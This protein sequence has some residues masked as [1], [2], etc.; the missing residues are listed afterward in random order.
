M[1]SCKFFKLNFFNK[2]FLFFILLLLSLISIQI[3]VKD[4]TLSGLV[5][6]NYQDTFIAF[7]S[8]IPRL[9]SIIITGASLSIAGLI[10]Q[11]I[12]NNKFLAPSTS[13]TM[14]WC[15]LGILISILFFGK[16]S[17]FIRIISA[18]FVSLLGNLF[19]MAILRKIKFKN[20]LMLPLVGIMLGTVVNSITTFFAYKF[21]II[22]NISSWLQGSFSLVI[23]GNYEILYIGVIALFIAYFFANKFTIA[24]MGQEI[25]TSLGLNYKVVVTI[26]LAI[27]SFITSLVVVTIGNISFVGLIVPNIVTMFK[28]DSIKSN[29][30]E[31][32]L[33]GS[34][35]VLVSDII[36]R[37]IIYPYEVSVS[38]IISVFGSL[39]F[40][41][42]LFRK[43]S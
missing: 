24:S 37:L 7:I 43:N 36:G 32:A 13:G 1:L 21:D 19:F 26:G 38:T 10:M 41:L 28:G 8:R 4:F 40:L 5:S 15:K 30:L 29:I 14:E 18:F 23:K 22:Q 35:F 31:T 27:V 9:L 17:N 6:G 39:L 12:T 16:S 11:T 33:F 34:I 25:S 3:G 2:Y 20:S 42:I